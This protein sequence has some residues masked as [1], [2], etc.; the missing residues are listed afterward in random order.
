MLRLLSTIRKELLILLRDRGGLAILFLMP[1]AMI[2]IMALI[3]DAP[4]RDYQELKIP[5][6]L[7]N[8]DTSTL[9]RTIEN[10]LKTSKIF[11]ITQQKQSEAAAK[12]LVKGGDYEIGII[13][14]ANATE[15]LNAKVN[16]FVS[17]KLSAAGLSDSVPAT[18]A[19]VTGDLNLVI[20]FAPDTKKSFKASVLSTLHQ[21]T[22]KLETQ[23]LLDYFSKEL[24]KND[25]AAP[26]QTQTKIDDL[27]GFKEINTV[28]TPQETLQL[29]SV[30]HNVPAWT[31]FG[32]FFIVISMAGSIIKERDDG[33]Y[34]RIR[35]MPGSYVTVM[36]GK[37]SAYLFI[38][39]I[40]CVLML[41]VGIYI[42]PLLGLPTLVIGNNMIAIA[43]VAI[44]CG[45]AATGYGILVGTLFSTHQ[46]SSTFGAVS[47]VILAALGGIW[48]PVYVMPESMRMLSEISPLYWALS[49][50][51]KLFIGGGTVAAILPYVLKLLLFFIFTLSG[52]FLFN[53]TKKQ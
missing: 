50:F 36:A 37:I 3:Q 41:L 38:C 49:A 11:E 40:Q 16:Q 29:N 51:H 5:L 48:V 32:M 31:I 4:F 33:S 53:K 1:M 34:T 14:P 35:T 30:Q 43:I 44:S 28:E 9:G 21:F 24:S 45:L 8:N 17:K 52:A 20:F 22:S 39:L 12:K 6:L 23:T 26:A 2:T 46:Q 19:T 7:V 47:I 27:V 13:I 15:L 10:G 42:L 18:T 25:N